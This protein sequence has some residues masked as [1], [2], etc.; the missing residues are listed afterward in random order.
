GLEADAGGGGD[1]DCAGG[2]DGY[3]G[4]DYV[5]VPVTLAGGY[6]AGEGE[7]G[8]GG[9]GDVLGAAD[10]GF[11]HAAA[12]DGDGIFLAE[13]VDTFCLEEA[14]DAAEFDV[15][16]FA[17]AESDGGFG[18]LVGVDALVEADGRFEIFFG[19]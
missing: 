12:P 7:V 4:S 3:F 9:H 18:L 16:D 1:L 19:F 2:R 14:A 13:I 8:E 15:D 10:A 5:F 11:E 6:V 17:G